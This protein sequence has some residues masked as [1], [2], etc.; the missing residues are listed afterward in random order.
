MPLY[1]GDY[2]ADTMHLTC[3]QHGAY[4]LLICAYWRRGGPLSNDD[5]QLAAITKLA[6]ADWRKM[7]SVMGEFFLIQGEEWRHKRVDAELASAIARSEERKR[8]GSN[9]ASARW[10]SRGLGNGKVIA[11]PLAEPL[12]NE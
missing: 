3:A 4:F 1:V 7:R 5:D 10:G 11:E 8:S 6:V 9:G 12:A 2:L